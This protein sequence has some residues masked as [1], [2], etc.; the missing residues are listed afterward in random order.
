MATASTFIQPGSEDVG[1]NGRLGFAVKVLGDGGLPSHDTRRWQS[2][3]HLRVSIERLHAVLGY[4]D[5]N[6]IRMYRIAS[7]FV[8]YAT[9]PDLPQ[10]HQQLTECA[11]ELGQL[12]ARAKELD[13]R[14]SF[15]PGQYT[16]LNSERPEVVE[17]ALRD[18]EL[19]ARVLDVMDQ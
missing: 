16:V 13:I 1:L 11:D 3:P 4:L 14:L 17:A 19:H 9:H 2:E 5:R 12:G 18:L 15:H 8:P 7:S 6:D 10:F